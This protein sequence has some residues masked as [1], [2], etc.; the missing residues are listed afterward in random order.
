MQAILSYDYLC[1]LSYLVDSGVSL[2]QVI[3]DKIQLLSQREGLDEFPD[4]NIALMVERCAI[5]VNALMTTGKDLDHVICLFCGM[6]P[7]VILTDGNTKVSASVIA[8]ITKS[9]PRF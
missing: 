8:G 2:I 3:Q 5:A 6:A 7:K 1:E 9:K 4:H